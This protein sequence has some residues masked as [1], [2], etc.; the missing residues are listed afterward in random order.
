MK[1]LFLADN[2]PPEAN[3]PA[4]RTYQHCRA[5]IRLGAAVTVITCAP[6]FPQGKVYPG[7]A[8]RPY[9]RENMD[10]IDV[11][12]VWTYIA[13][14]SG[15][16]R[17]I[18]DYVSFAASSL[19]AG[20]FLDADVIVATSPQLFTA[21][22]GLG[23]S[24]AKRTPWVF[25][26][27]D[28]WPDSIRAVSAIKNAPVL[29]YLEK[30]ELFLYRRADLV[31]AVTPAFKR[32]LIERGIPAEKIEVVTNG[33]D[34]EMF[35]R[36]APD[37]TLRARLG[38]TGKFVV[39]YVGTH[40][41]AHNLETLIAA[42]DR[43]EDPDVAFLCIGDGA[44]KR[45]LKEIVTQKRLGNV[46]LMDPVPKEEI[47]RYWSILDV[48]LVPLRKDPVFTSVIPSKIFEAAAM[49]KPILLG[50]EGQARELIDAYDAGV[51]FEPDNTD[52][53]L[54]KVMLL[55]RDRALYGRL[56]AHCARLAADF[57]RDTLA[58]SMYR[59]LVALVDKSQRATA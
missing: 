37:E 42:C 35:Q 34:L 22:G 20:A 41:M 10:G 52:E 48:A 7:Y 3:A 47:A 1:I 30:L 23:L 12:R 8:N 55:H 50:V 11:I 5:W 49:G 16:A 56:S 53:F 28:L 51:A 21:L 54:E 43:C 13:E 9:T 17:R 40:G 26:L 19:L 58:A 36:H 25:E 32:N 57:D 45:A 6:N 31:V 24:V 39:G 33:V 44:R 14:N 29:A 15:F 2:F 38:L 27:R 59:H 18:L 46:I 4:T